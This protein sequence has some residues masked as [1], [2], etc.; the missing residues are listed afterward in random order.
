MFSQRMG[1]GGDFASDLQVAI[2]QTSRGGLAA[3]FLAS[4]RRPAHRHRPGWRSQSSR[5]KATEAATISLRLPMPA[6]GWLYRSEFPAPVSIRWA[7]PPDSDR[8]SVM[9]EGREGHYLKLQL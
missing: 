4:L 7:E 5:S 3:L 1:L 8:D 9:I 6:P 2:T